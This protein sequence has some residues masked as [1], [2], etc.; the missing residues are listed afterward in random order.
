MERKTIAVSFSLPQETCE[1]LEELAEWMGISKSEV[2]GKA[3]KQYFASEKRWQ[4]IRRY[5]E[6]TA[7]RLG[8]KDEGDIDRMI[9]E[10]RQDKSRY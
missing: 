3:L 6:E 7:K 5:G 2:L 10:F 4:Q 8:L 9:H 1:Q